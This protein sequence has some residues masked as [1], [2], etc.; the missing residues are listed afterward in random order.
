[1][2]GHPSWI[3]LTK[4]IVIRSRILAAGLAAVL[5]TAMSVAPTAHAA[6]PAAATP[7]HTA[8]EPATRKPAHKVAY[9]TFDDGP[10]AA[11]TPA[12]L[13]ILARHRAKA[14][15]FM[16]G[17][18]AER[19]PD[20]LRAVRAQGHAVGNHTFTHPNLTRSTPAQIA[21][22]LARTDAALGHTTCLR[23]PGGST[24]PRVHRIARAHGLTTVLWNVDTR[25]WTRPGASAITA[26]A[27]SPLTYRGRSPV[28][29]L[30]DGGG[31]RSQSVAALPGI[32]RSLERQGYRFET[33]PACR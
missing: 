30:H 22:E 10:T 28:I 27:V 21:S 3:A 24:D 14:T 1:M 5:A 31:D 25:D 9:L 23:P 11:Y 8:A 15:F 19:R 32:L 18:Q 33:L 2:P 20:L 17:S 16:I 12:V 13:E 4:G 26:A 29:L 7:A 6:E